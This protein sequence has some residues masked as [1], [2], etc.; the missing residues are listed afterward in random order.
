[1]TNVYLKSIKKLFDATDPDT[2]EGHELVDDDFTTAAKLFDDVITEARFET[3]TH[4][5]R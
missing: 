2:E 1:M 3:T 4:R 5:R